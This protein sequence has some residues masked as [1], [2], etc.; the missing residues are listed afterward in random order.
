MANDYSEDILTE[1]TTMDLLRDGLKWHTAN[2]MIGETFGERGT[3]GRDSETDVL[4][5]W[6]FLRAVRDLNPHLPTN[7]L[8][9]AFDKL[10]SRDVSKSAAVIN[11]DK[12]QMLRDGVP[13]TFRNEEGEIDKK[14]VRIFNFERPTKNDFLAVQQMWLEGKSKRRK[15]PDVIGFVNGIPLLFVELKRHDKKIRSGY[16]GN[17][18]D[19]KKTL[20]SL[21]DC[22]AFIIL[23]NG[24][25]SKV[26]TLTSKFEH[27]HEWK[28][29]KE[30]ETGVVSLETVLRGMCDKARFLDLFENFVLFDESDG[31]P[32]KLVARNHQF[33]GVN[34]AIAHV[35]DLQKKYEQGRIE[36]VDLQKL[37]IFWHTQGS[38]K[39]YSMVFLTQKIHQKLTGNYTFVIV[40]D[41]L[42]LDEQIYGTFRGVKAVKDDSCRAKSGKKLK[43]LLG[44]DARYI[45]TLIH[46]FN[47][48][49]VAS[50]RSD[51][52][53]LSDEAHRTQGGTL[54]LNMRNA[55]P[56]ASFMGFTG[57]PLF[58]DDELTRRIFGDYISVYDFKRSVEDGATVPLYYENRGEKLQLKNPKINEEIREALEN[59]NMD[60]QQREKVNRLLARDYPILTS[61][62]R[63]RLIAK[64][65]VEHF[66]ERGYQG[67]AMF[68]ALDKLT[69]VK[70]YNYITEAWAERLARREKEIDRLPDLLEQKVQKRAW[71][72]EKETE[73]AVV[74][75]HEQGE[76]DKFEA[77]DLDIEPH[78]LKMNTQDLETD[79][80]DETHPFR[81]AIVCAMWI[82]GFDVK[83]LS[84][85]YLDKP[86]KSHTLMQTIARAN[87]IHEGKNNGLIVDYIETYKSLL[88][89]LAVY[90][91]GGDKGGK[92][93]GK[94]EPPVRPLEEEM[95]QELEEALTAVEKFLLE[96]VNFS[97][98]KLIG[99]EGLNR[100]AA[101]AEGENAIYTTDN[102]KAKF[103]VL[104]RE[105]FKKFKAFT[106][107]PGTQV[108]RPRRDAINAL[109]TRITDNTYE[110]DI[111]GIMSRVQDVVDSSITELPNK[112]ADDPEVEYTSTTRVDL[113]K[114]DFDKIEK[115]FLKISNKN[116]VLQ[117][118]KQRIERQLETML[119]DNPT[120]IDFHEKYEEIISDYNRGKDYRT[121]KEIFDRLKAL[122]DKLTEEEERAERENLDQPELTIFDILSQGKK[123]SDKEKLKLKDI[124]VKLLKRLLDRELSTEHWTVNDQTT[125]AVKMVIHETLYQELPYPT[126]ENETEIEQKTMKLLDY[127]GERFGGLAA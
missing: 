125:A 93:G 25:E 111:S 6:R 51:I 45:F 79:F 11:H 12:Y 39:S 96:E 59:E 5:R 121:I 21:F 14:T 27:Y 54:A 3:I 69:A 118:V 42:E 107:H 34:K 61:K 46:R 40:T 15:R 70:M 48:T 80:K 35:S 55:L 73:V 119:R 72:L 68:V 84:T 16:D 22:N 104:A 50:E 4:L 17:L 24:I 33:I 88:E 102:T 57:T 127:F 90:A 101:I 23:S 95:T 103:L 64:D 49:E 71:L 37:G 8:Q 18:K 30:N 76:I 115:E 108:F 82:T 36:A 92:K 62:L 20:A 32:A 56:N 66:N 31:T 9:A 13:V 106:P 98:Q 123:V 85:L 65:V 77:Y 100:L 38:G 29:I 58:K 41:R 74:V 78:R 63:L 1:K 126:F 52:I 28:R 75:S 120:R 89:A 7:A 2:V 10:Q 110:A 117:S 86:M 87:R 116:T 60:S 53:V 97:L 91:V 99:S 122:F 109:Y 83:S 94:P 81:F 105:V 43:E 124:A 113:S 47:F 112:K 44:T 114:L 19:Y 67:K 26:G